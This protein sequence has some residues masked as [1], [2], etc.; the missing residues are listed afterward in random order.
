MAQ[1][2]ATRSRR[3]GRGVA[4]LRGVCAL[5]VLLT[6]AGCTSFFRL[7]FGSPPEGAPDHV[8]DFVGGVVADE[9]RAAVNARAVLSA[10]GNAVD[11][12][13]A[14]GF[15]LATT[16][17][18][19]AGLGAGGACLVY[20]PGARGP[21]GLA[22]ETISFMPTAPA[23]PPASADRPASVPMLARGLYAL[24]VRYGHLPFDDLVSPAEVLARFGV[25]VSHALALDLGVVGD[26]LLADRSAHLGFGPSGSLLTEGAMM[27]QT[28]LGGT[29]AQILSAGVSDLYDG[30][31]ARQVQSAAD[32][33]GGGLS[34][35]DFAAALPRAIAPISL[36]DGVNS[37][38]F[39]PPPADGGLAAAAAFRALRAQ[40]KDLAAAGA[41]ALRVAGQARGTAGL[42]QAL[43]ASTGFVTLDP[44]GGVVACDVTMG[45]LFG[46]G[47]IAPGTGILLGASPHS[48][49]PPLLAAAIA[50]NPHRHAV[51]AA[52]TA[53]GQSGA[54]LA[55]AEGMV[56]A[57]APEVIEKPA[58]G[59]PKRLPD[60]RPNVMPR[61]V[62]DPGRLNV[63]G[64]FKYLPGNRA[65]CGWANDP[66]L[67]GAALGYVEPKEEDQ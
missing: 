55:L 25:P 5:G 59:K 67:S 30:T 28:D 18:S 27:V 22:P 47:R 10:G 29:L 60:E 3:Q 42:P 62:P 45:N 1:Q 44:H 33:A 56:D 11:A 63:I 53:S 39:L 16:L 38:A 2:T 9:P 40:P 19:R 36:D 20:M 48:M 7:I 12:A 58:K 6:T 21:A 4:V 41:E 64:C 37:I 52:A 49:P 8:I 15:T 23:T 32:A 51:R 46:T 54:P 43:P 17:P 66:R 35:A 13:V 57:L 61:Q 34:R 24:H 31:L 14:L 26:A 65:S 50:W